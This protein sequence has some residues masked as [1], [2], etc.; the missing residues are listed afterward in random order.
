MKVI[1]SRLRGM[2][3]TKALRRR[4][5]GAGLDIMKHDMLSSG[6]PV[7]WDI[8]QGVRSRELIAVLHK[9][10]HDTEQWAVRIDRA[11]HR[12]TH[13]SAGPILTMRDFQPE[14][15]YAYIYIR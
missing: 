8:E 15:R 10:G 4:A 14:V 5:V 11:S 7:A 12:I 13:V 3:H 9:R 1:P 6:N 2:A